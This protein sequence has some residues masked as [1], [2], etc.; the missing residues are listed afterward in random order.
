VSALASRSPAELPG[1]VQFVD[2]GD[3]V[4]T[5]ENFHPHFHVIALTHDKAW[6]REVQHGTDCIVPIER[7]RRIDPSA[8][9]VNRR[10]GPTGPSANDDQIQSR[11]SRC[12]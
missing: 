3:L 8:P 6:I 11:S 5:G 2:V 10:H 1:E 9:L 4:R 12:N 7:C